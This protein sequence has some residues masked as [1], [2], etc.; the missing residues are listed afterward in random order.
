L[1]EICSTPIIDLKSSHLVAVSDS[2]TG[3][4]CSLK[5]N[6]GESHSKIADC[7]DYQVLREFAI[8]KKDVS[9]GGTFNKVI[10]CEDH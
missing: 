7:I 6:G 2:G 10:I 4:I 3:F 1:G 9:R 5:M 8:S